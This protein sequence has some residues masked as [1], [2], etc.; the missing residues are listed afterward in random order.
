MFK[1]LT[2]EVVGNDRLH[3]EGCEERVEQAL[4]KVP[5]VN[6][7]R[8]K[9]SNQRVKVL[10]DSSLLDADAITAHVARVG[11]Q[12]KVVSAPTDES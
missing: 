3:C 4:K 9:S 1:S 5:G 7:V 6:Q 11:Y 2:L 10:F 8:A 12:T